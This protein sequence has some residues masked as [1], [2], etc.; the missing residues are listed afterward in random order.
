MNSSESEL[1]TTQPQCLCK[2]DQAFPPTL[3]HMDLKAAV[4]RQPN[5]ALGIVWMWTGE[6]FSIHC[7]VWQFGQL[8]TLAKLSEPVSVL[9]NFPP[10]KFSVQWNHQSS[11]HFFCVS[12]RNSRLRKELCTVR[13]THS[14]GTTHHRL[15]FLRHAFFIF[16]FSLLQWRK[17]NVLTLVNWQVARVQVSFRLV[18]Q[19]SLQ[20]LAALRKSQDQWVENQQC[21]CKICLFLIPTPQRTWAEKTE[22]NQS[23]Q[24]RCRN[25][26]QTD[27]H[28]WNKTPAI[29]YRTFHLSWSTKETS[30]GNSQGCPSLQEKRAS[31]PPSLMFSV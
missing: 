25:S 3:H 20:L 4:R 1:S 14:D 16:S 10:C 30:S 2:R 12:Y 18:E 9:G 22:R 29:Q 7:P 23:L 5:V 6:I 19:Q 13:L 24:A 31:C 8:H 21:Q 26:L 15:L 11:Q 28:A 27:H 17:H